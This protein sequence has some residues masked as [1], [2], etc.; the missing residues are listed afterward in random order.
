MHVN[1][2]GA[3]AAERQELEPEAF[4]GTAMIVVDDVNQARKEAGELIALDR[5]DRLDWSQVRSLA[6]VV[7][8]HAPAASERGGITIF[9]SLGTAIEDLA[10]ASI[11]YDG[12]VRAGIGAIV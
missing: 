12:A 7:A 4:A 9:K 1:A 3:N 10:A 5:Q 8:G 6:D 11:V 2:I